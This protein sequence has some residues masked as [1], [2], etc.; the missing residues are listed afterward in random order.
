MLQQM[1]KFVNNPLTDHTT[2]PRHGLKCLNPTALQ[3]SLK[4]PSVKQTVDA[5]GGQFE[6]LSSIVDSGATIPTMH[7]GDA[8]AYE[9]QE[10]EASR[11][12]V[13]YEVANGETVPNLGEK[14]FAVLTKEGTLR[15]YQTQCAEVV[16][17]KPLQAVR[18]LLASSHAVCFGLG[19]AG[20]QNLIIN[21]DTGEINEMRDDGINYI[22]DVLVIPADKIEE[23]Q[24][25]LAALRE[26]NDLNG[27][28]FDWQGRW[29]WL[30]RW[31][32]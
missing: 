8:K 20:D 26:S 29:Q 10:S 31:N 7:P 25:Q 30:L 4:P 21:K 11:R 24:Q 5:L 3:S 27:Q 18:A 15:G 6:V 13:E 12:G 16:P 22:Q 32:P 17:G 14:K 9:L 2:I 23:V 19:E 28:D 1:L